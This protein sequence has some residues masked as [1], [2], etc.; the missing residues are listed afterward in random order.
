[1]L[2]PDTSSSIEIVKA[3]MDGKMPL[4]P[5]F[6][7]GLVDVRDV[8]DLHLRAMTD[9]AAKG[10][11]FLAVAGETMSIHEIAGVLRRRLGRAAARRSPQVRDALPQLGQIRRSSSEKARRVLG[12]TPRGNEEIIVATAESLLR[13]ALVKP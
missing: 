6:H 10:E 4:S 1:V 13:L 11:R 2:G 3:L 8:A 9:P 7:F 5:Q 12:W